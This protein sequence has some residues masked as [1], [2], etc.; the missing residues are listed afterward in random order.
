MLQWV[1]LGHRMGA[2]PKALS[3]G[4][5]QRLAI[6]RAVVAKPDLIL[7]DEPTASVD[8]AMA[9]RLM[10]LFQTLNR[11]GTTVLIA[12]H[13]EALAVRSGATVLRLVDGRLFGG[14]R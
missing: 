7:A 6:A 3:G 13:E 9:D 10:S 11:M 12:G 5:K 2:R 1:G 8:A 14:V 4:E